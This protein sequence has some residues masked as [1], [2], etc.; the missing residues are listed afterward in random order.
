MQ[1]N[2]KKKKKPKKGKVKLP[3]RGPYKDRMMRAEKIQGF[4]S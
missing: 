2:T 3:Q 1:R 4:G